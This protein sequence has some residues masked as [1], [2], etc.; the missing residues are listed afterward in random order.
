M[1]RT[2]SFVRITTIFTISTTTTCKAYMR[3][4]KKL[5]FQCL[6]F[7]GW[8]KA[9]F[10][11]LNPWSSESDRET[12]ITI[13]HIKRARLVHTLD[14][15]YF[16][17]FSFSVGCNALTKI[18]IAKKHWIVN[19]NITRPR[20]L[21]LNWSKG[22]RPSSSSSSSSPSSSFSNGFYIKNSEFSI[23]FSSSI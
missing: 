10:I 9:Y 12:C 14:G 23:V 17:G 19:K 4:A 16:H 8:F 15:N 1:S 21:V 11:I 2:A 13:P 22:S 6:N 3:P 5:T 18:R 7:H 20:I